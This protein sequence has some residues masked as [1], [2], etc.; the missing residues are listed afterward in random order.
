MVRTGLLASGNTK[1]CGCKQA[2]KTVH[3]HLK[4]EGVYAIRFA[5]GN[6]KFGRSSNLLIRLRQYLQLAIVAGGAV[7]YV[8]PCRDSMG[9]ERALIRWAADHAKNLAYETFK[10]L[11]LN[12]VLAQLKKASRGAI[13]E[14]RVF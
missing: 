9:K 5:S 10:G 7:G 3:D 1:S 2:P 12:D 4:C 8:A 14:Y 6:I 11:Q 13:S